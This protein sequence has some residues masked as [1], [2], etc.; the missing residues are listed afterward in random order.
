VREALQQP[1]A[2]AVTQHLLRGA[3][4]SLTDPHHPSGMPNG[5]GCA[6]LRRS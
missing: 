1:T 6:R 4:D 2:R 5:A 3:V